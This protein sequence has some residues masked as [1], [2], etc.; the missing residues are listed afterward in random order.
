MKLLRLSAAFL[1]FATFSLSAQAELAISANDG[2]Q[3][4]ADDT[5]SVPVPD[6]VSVLDIR[7]GSAKVLASIAAPATMIGPPTSVAVARDSRFALVAGSQKLV[8][9]KLV[10]NDTLSVIDLSHPS[11]PK[12]SQTLHAGAGATGVSI[13]PSGKLALVANTGDDSVSAFAISG[14]RL[15]PSGK[16]TLDPK[17]APTDVVFSRDGKTALVVGRGNSRLMLLSVKGAA[18]ALTG[19]G[20]QPG[21]SPYSAAITHDGKYVI[22]NNLGGATLAK[23]ASSPAAPAGRGRA[24]RP[25][26][27]LSLTDIKTGE[28]V[29][30]VETG[31][32]P[33]GLVLSPDGRYVVVDAGNGSPNSPSSP[34]FNKSFG[35][36]EIYSVGSGSLTPIGRADTGHWCQGEAFSKD[37]KTILVQCAAEKEIEVFHFDGKTITRDPKATL[38]I[39]SRPGAIATAF[40]R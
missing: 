12:V 19:V 31:A 21:M 10:P 32:A 8:K 25:P 20:F 24:P 38:F 34:D 15:A 30:S 4:R 29:A 5:I 3:V 36:L 35:R 13:S 1:C 23:T 22:T 7:N 27:T 37:G 28:V 6:T 2:K 17:S 11:D 33:E 9:G 16:V 18:V 26:A 14:R 40:S 39:G